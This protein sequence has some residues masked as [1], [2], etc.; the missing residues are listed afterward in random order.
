MMDQHQGKTDRELLMETRIAVDWLKE[1]LEKHL[2][3]HSRLNLVAVGAV[4]SFLGAV[5]LVVVGK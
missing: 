5:L 2:E 4:L 1:A 3:Q